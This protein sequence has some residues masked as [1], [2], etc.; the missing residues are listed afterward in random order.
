MN[1]YIQFLDRTYWIVC[2]ECPVCFNKN[3]GIPVYVSIDSCFTCRNETGIIR[4]SEGV[5]VFALNKKIT[6]LANRVSIIL[7]DSTHLFRQIY[8]CLP[9]IHYILFN[10]KSILLHSASIVC[11]GKCMLLVG[12]SGA[13]KTT[14]SNL[15]IKNEYPVLSDELNIIVF[16]IPLFRE[17]FS[18]LGVDFFLTEC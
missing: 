15:A 13:G 5:E 12:E 4:Y 8:E 3:T 18:V 17:R 10:V 1:E 7:R 16:E 2:D 11:D 6:V 14:F 9:T